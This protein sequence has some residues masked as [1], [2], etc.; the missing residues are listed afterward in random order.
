MIVPESIA[1]AP[2]WSGSRKTACEPNDSATMRRGHVQPRSTYSAGGSSGCRRQCSASFDP[3]NKQGE[4]GS[5]ATL[6]ALADASLLPYR[7]DR[8]QG[9]QVVDGAHERNAPVTCVRARMGDLVEQD[10]REVSRRVQH[11]TL[12]DD[13]GRVP[14]AFGF[15][16]RLIEP[17]RHRDA[18]LLHPLRVVAGQAQNFG[19]D[20]PGL[21]LGRVQPGWI[22]EVEMERLVPRLDEAGEVEDRLAVEVAEVGETRSHSVGNRLDL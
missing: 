18:H 3:K 15:V 7:L 20:A 22:D 9:G 14:H 17:H 8:A 5:T 11:R 21:P 19:K 13:V 16:L 4:R 10:P 12:D 1:I 6:S 2:A